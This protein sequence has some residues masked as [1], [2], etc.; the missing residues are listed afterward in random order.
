ML[1]CK[2]SNSVKEL[3]AEPFELTTRADLRVSAENAQVVEAR[4]RDSERFK[5]EHSASAHSACVQ[6]AVDPAENWFGSYR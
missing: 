5:A 6:I 2:Y 1:C 3:S 4:H